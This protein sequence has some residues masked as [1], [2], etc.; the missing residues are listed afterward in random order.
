MSVPLCSWLLCSL[1]SAGHWLSQCAA[2]R[3][4]AVARS[5]HCA[6]LHTVGAPLRCAPR[7]E[8]SHKGTSSAPRPFSV[9][10]VVSTVS[11]VVALARALRS[12]S[13]ALR[14]TSRP[15]SVQLPV[16]MTNS[17]KLYGSQNFLRSEDAHEGGNG[18]KTNA[19]AA[20]S[21]QSSN[22]TAPRIERSPGRWD[23][24]PGTLLISE[25]ELIKRVNE[26]VDEAVEI[27]RDE[28]K[29]IAHQAV[30][31]PLRGRELRIARRT[32]R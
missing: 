11:A 28:I 6:Q 4:A 17:R 27:L 8:K 13:A 19:S 24:E 26:K 16:D 15:G 10:R 30:V 23:I 1:L 29:A 18:E 20:G 12:A 7:P 25:D 31:Q 9:L 14:L 21:T 2:S 32:L 5:S 3:A 22:G